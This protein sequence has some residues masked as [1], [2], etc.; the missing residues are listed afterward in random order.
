[1]T[2]F[3]FQF[4]ISLINLSVIL[5]LSFQIEKKNKKIKQIMNKTYHTLLETFATESH[6]ELSFDYV[7]S[8]IANTI[9]VRKT[10]ILVAY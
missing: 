3:N 4:R 9:R 6:S 8:T 2:F 10:N 7:K 5:F 1:M